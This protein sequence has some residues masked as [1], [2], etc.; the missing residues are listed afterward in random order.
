MFGGVYEGRRVF[1]TGHTGFKGS[2]LTLWLLDL[3]AQVTGYALDP[4]TCPSLFVELG[5]ESHV[6]HIIAD[7]RDAVRLEREMI[8]ATPEVVIHLAAQPIVRESY[9]QPRMTFETN[10]MGTVNVLEA[11]RRSETVKAVVVVTSDK[12]YRNRGEMRAFTED[13][14]M[15]GRDP[16]S[17]SKGCAELVSVAYGASFF[18]ERGVALATARAGNVIGGGD[19]ADDR[20]VPDCVRALAAG[21]PVP[22]RNPDAIRPWQHVLESLAGYLSLGASLLKDGRSFAGAWN[23]GPSPDD[24]LAV[25][26]VVETFLDAWGGGAW[27]APAASGPHL[28]EAAF[29]A[30]DSGKARDRL[31][32]TPVWDAPEAVR[33][34]AAWYRGYARDPRRA[35]SLVEDDLAAYAAAAG[36]PAPEV[37]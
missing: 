24:S 7:V 3:G 20:L 13:D 37:A 9:R 36:E 15:G 2:W 27:T 5:L 14:A 26:W 35:R 6:R 11:A 17:A 32:W 12:C 16:Y 30:L 29:L 19:W 23:F 10:V 8:A 31:G 33:R 4:P 22:V 18:D 1:I 34:T 25:Q 28:A 21:E